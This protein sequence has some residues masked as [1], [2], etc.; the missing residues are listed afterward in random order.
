MA[1]I[2]ERSLKELEDLY[3]SKLEHWTRRQDE[4]RKELEESQQ[5][6]E[7]Y[8]QKL[9]M[10]GV[11]SGTPVALPA[12]VAAARRAPAKAGG[13]RKQRYS[14][15]KVATLQVLRSRPGERMTVKQI[16]AAIR[17]DTSR[18]VS[19]QAINV[20]VD[21]LEEEGKIRRDRAPKGANARFVFSAVQAANGRKEVTMRKP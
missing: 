17:K 12:P 3:K 13:K 14:P 5:Q 21:K 18:R 16:R 10:V 1:D 11:L 7:T 8:E 19:R 4:I 15:V 20:N 9:R 2:K 6:I